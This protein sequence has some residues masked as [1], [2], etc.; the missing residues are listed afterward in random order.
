VLYPSLRD[1]LLKPHYRHR[2]MQI[3]GD[4]RF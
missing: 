3:T 1:S 2:L 4:S